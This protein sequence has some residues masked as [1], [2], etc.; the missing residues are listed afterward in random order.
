[1]KT[2]LLGRVMAVTA[3]FAVSCSNTNETV[4][5][6]E[7]GPL[8][9][10]V[11]SLDTDVHLQIPEGALGQRVTIT[12]APT[13]AAIPGA[14]GTAYEIGPTG[15]TF[16]Q[17]VTLTFHYDPAMIGSLPLSSIVIATIVSGEWQPIDGIVASTSAQTI[18]GTTTH[19]STYALWQRAQVDAGADQNP[20]WCPVDAPHNAT[21]CGSGGVCNYDSVAGHGFAYC[22]GHEWLVGFLPSTC[23]AQLPVAESCGAFS[24]TC[25]YEHAAPS[26]PFA[27]SG[28]IDTC[29]CRRGKWACTNDCECAPA[30]Q[31]SCESTLGTSPSNGERGY[32][33]G[34]NRCSKSLSTN[35][36]GVF[37]ACN[38]R[39]SCV[40]HQWTC[41]ETGDCS[42]SC[43][44]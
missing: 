43:V 35:I 40:S 41:I 9:G 27:S 13:L 33:V 28:C 26:T 17:P 15:T 29:T 12:I 30:V 25:Q 14:I 2:T 8:G 10:I 42:D 20:W 16:A 21:P 34:D 11:G 39:C 23:P 44:P 24:D 37:S 4:A 31:V 6:Q 3:M 32:C 18:S 7:V 36:D 1:M 38:V 22:D 5:S 19:L